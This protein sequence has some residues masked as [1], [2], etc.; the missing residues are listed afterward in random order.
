VVMEGAWRGQ[1]G[2]FH[3]GRSCRIRAQAAAG[4]EEDDEED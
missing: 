4:E 1:F 2:D 3:I